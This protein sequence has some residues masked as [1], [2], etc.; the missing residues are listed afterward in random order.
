MV[1][2][3]DEEMLRRIAA[4]GGGAFVRATQ[5]STGINELV[6]ELR[7]MDQTEIGTYRFAGHEDR[8]QFPLA[9]G[10]ALLL[11]SLILPERRVF[12]TTWTNEHGS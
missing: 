9:I 1:S 3:L 11:L 7:G 6:N 5:S 8:S 2:R 12:R 4:A 10:C